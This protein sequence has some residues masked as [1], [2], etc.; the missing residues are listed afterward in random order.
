MLAHSNADFLGHRKG[1]R[2]SPDRLPV[3]AEDVVD[4]LAQQYG[5]AMSDS[6]VAPSCG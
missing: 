2:P 6:T 1:V 4:M 3:E 5:D